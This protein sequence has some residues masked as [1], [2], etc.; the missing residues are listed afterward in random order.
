MNSDASGPEESQLEVLF[1]YV[2]IQILGS[3]KRTYAVKHIYLL[4]NIVR[5]P[6]DK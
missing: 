2:E 6:T 1:S 5:K 3:Y 4:L